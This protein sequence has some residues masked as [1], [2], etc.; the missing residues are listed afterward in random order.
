MPAK[1]VSD[2]KILSLLKRGYTHGMVKKELRVDK[3]VVRRVALQNIAELSDQYKPES[4]ELR[5][6]CVELIAR[7]MAAGEWEQHKVTTL[8]KLY[9]VQ[10]FEVQSWAIIAAKK[11][12]RG[13]DPVVL[14]SMLE[15]TLYELRR[16]AVHC[17]RQGRPEVSVI[18]RKAIGS[19]IVSLSKNDPDRA[20]M[21]KQI[22]HIHQQP[23]AQNVSA[24]TGVEELIAKGWTPP[25]PKGLPPITDDEAALNNDFDERKE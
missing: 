22:L 20:K 24:R 16:L 10:R 2:A 8:V 1:R 14:S 18:A 5:D 7:M 12:R 3:E 9:G 15:E 11:V 13:L 21:T 25:A 6:A 23:I 4:G 19:I 17:E